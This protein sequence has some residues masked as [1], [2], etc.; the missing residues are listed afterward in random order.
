VIA[1]ADDLF[2]F[3]WNEKETTAPPDE[4]LSENCVA[5]ESSADYDKEE[6]LTLALGRALGKDIE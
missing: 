1:A 5:C 4:L 2:E 3:L 6:R